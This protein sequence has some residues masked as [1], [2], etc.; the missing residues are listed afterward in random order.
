[1]RDK[2]KEIKMEITR[3]D[4]RLKERGNMAD[5]I[6]AAVIEELGTSGTGQK[7]SSAEVVGMKDEAVPKITGGSSP[8]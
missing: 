7:Q 5:I 1:M 3:L 8:S 2:T 6:K 4:T